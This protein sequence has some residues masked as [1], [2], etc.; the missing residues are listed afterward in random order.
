[1]D[2]SKG[3]IAVKDQV[4]IS[5][6]VTLAD[7]IWREHYTSIIGKPQVDY[8]LE[9][10]QSF[11][12]IKSQIAEGA[13]YY[14]ISYQQ[15]PAG[16]FSFYEKKHT[17]FLSKIYVKSSLRGK[18]LG[19]KAISFI[20]DEAKRIGLTSIVLTVN[21]NNEWSII[22]YK[23]MGFEINRPLVMDIGGGFVMDDYEMEKKIK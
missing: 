16:Y 19:K 4:Q 18:G 6:I 17:L 7:E 23:K 8:M 11:D 20:E 3:I 1:M 2:W 13:R 9:N 15:S 10:F 22:A 5:E 12:A 21:K 14:L